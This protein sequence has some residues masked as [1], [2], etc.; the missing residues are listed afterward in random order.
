M[1]AEG[2]T[3]VKVETSA[4]P[5]ATEELKSESAEEQGEIS[6]SLAFPFGN[7]KEFLHRRKKSI[8]ITLGLFLIASL[9][10]PHIANIE[11]SSLKS[12][13]EAPVASTF[14]ETIQK[15]KQ[16]RDEA[17]RNESALYALDLFSAANQKEE[18]ANQALQA[19]QYALA[20]SL[21]FGFN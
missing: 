3:N 10:G 5:L 11:K 19:M 9:I 12:S 8:S 15:V 18:E 7:L 17:E 2:N 21:F 4:K 1:K 16:A 20:D 14:K 6:V 13:K